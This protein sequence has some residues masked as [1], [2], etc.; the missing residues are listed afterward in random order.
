MAVTLINPTTATITP[1]YDSTINSN[2]IPATQ[3]SIGDYI[4]VSKLTMFLQ[5]LSKSDELT[6]TN[7]PILFGFKNN[8]EFTELIVNA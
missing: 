3:F 4:K 6:D 2:K 5:D 1:S 7:T 8:R